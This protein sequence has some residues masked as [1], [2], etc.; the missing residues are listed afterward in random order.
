MTLVS[1]FANCLTHLVNIVLGPGYPT[2]PRIIFSLIF[3]TVIFCASI[4]FTQVDTDSWQLGF[5]F[6]S[7]AFCILL[8]INDS[9]FAGDNNQTDHSEDITIFKALSRP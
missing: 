6:L 1:V 9:I 2:R 8:N 5:Y 3:N 7:L 4:I